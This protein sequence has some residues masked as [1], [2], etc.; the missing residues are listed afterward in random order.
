VSASVATR[1]ISSFGSTQKSLASGI[2]AAKSEIKIFSGNEQL[3]D[4]STKREYHGGAVCAQD[5]S[6]QKG[7]KAK[8]DG[9]SVAYSM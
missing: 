4:S 6:H 1:L 8:N 2:V 5:Y 7:G 3:G 9:R